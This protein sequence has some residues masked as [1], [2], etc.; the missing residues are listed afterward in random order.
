MDAALGPPEQMAELEEDLTPMMAQYYELC[1][2][3][4]DALV[5]FQVGDFYEAFCAAAKRVARL[6][7]I[8]LTQ[9]ED[10]TGEYPM[11]GIPIDNAESYVET[12]LDAGYRVA[13]ADQ[14]E[15]PDEVSGVVERAVTR[16]VTPGTLTESELLGGADNNYVA[17]L[18]AGERYGLALLDISTGDCYA[19]SVGSESAVA[20]ELSRFGPAEAIVGPDVDVD[21]D[22]VFGPACL[23]TRYDADAF[24]Q[25]RA[26]DRV[27]QYFGPPERLL[28][29]G[30][31]IR[32]CGGLLAYAEYTRGSSGAVGPDGEPV[33][34]DVDPAGTL[35]YL[36]HL[37]RYDPREY[38]LLDAVAVESLELFKRRSVRGHEN[39]TLVDTV[40]ETAC[41]LGRR[42]LTDW[43]RRPLLDADRIEARHGA[44][45]ELQRDPATRE[46]LSAL[47][48]EVYDLERLI[49][50]VSRGRAN[51]RDLRSLAATLSVVPDIRDHLADADARLLA[52]LHA[53]LD[54][55][56]ETREEIEAAIR[57][58]PPQQVTEGGVIREG[59]D[60]ELDRLR[61]TEQSGKEWIDELEASERERTGIDSLKVGHTSVHGYYIEVTNAN[62]DAVPEDYQ[63]RQTLK[64][65]ERYYTPAL[66][67]REDEI[68][69]AESAADDL[70]YD[71]FCAVRDE[72][73]DEA[74]RV[75][76]LAD[77]LARLDVLV[78]FAEVAAQYDYC[79][80][81]VGSD[82]IDVT[83]GRHPVVERTEDAFIPN[84]THLGSGP[85]P[86]SR[87]GSDD[88]VTADDIQ[89]FLAV[90]TGP[91]MSGKSTYM[92]QVALICLLAQSGSFVPAKAADLPILD[93]VF[94]RV[95]ASDDIAGGRSTFMI[96]MTELATILD[97]ATENSLVLL[98]EVGRGTST[99]DGLAI[100]RAVTEYLH[101][102]VGAYTLFATHHHDLTAVAAALSGATNRH[103]ETSR[104]D[105]DVRFDHEL[106]PGPAAASYGV[107]VASMAGVPDSVVERSRDLLA[108]A[109]TADTGVE[110]TRETEVA[111]E[112]R[113]GT[114]ADS[115]TDS[116][117]TETTGP[118]ENGAASAPAG[119]ATSDDHAQEVFQT[120]GAA[121]EDELPESVAQQLASLDVATMTPIEAMNALADLQ[122]RI[123]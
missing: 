95:G 111:S 75:Q 115:E 117:A 88:G 18:T 20:D 92:R 37:T 69:R 60:E 19:T 116:T 4:D 57:P 2:Q 1:R 39:R 14:V 28:A 79:R 21:R 99:A 33:D 82:G 91:N 58:D 55:L 103:F 114:R 80:P 67:E 106:A 16:I 29:G 97:A 108:D 101:D 78:S 61:S 9:R 30:A 65:S 71:L 50:R 41:A 13:I 107:E 11:A 56:A 94:T 86:A 87:D 27:G 34:P 25:D 38:M 104:E 7:E 15:D 22:A 36:N 100:A 90:V 68:L 59:Y 105:G 46:E 98:D 62:L 74:E 93:R 42:K 6:C 45:A 96:E 10:S 47:L 32:A 35:D 84:D 83:A 102:E 8:T 81:T 54:P 123:E 5:L 53:T 110:A 64:N 23:V 119:E 109:E 118:T 120:N 112:P 66:K 113:P 63:R 121:A 72:V 73:A 89:P 51:A 31:E 49:S 52:D 85:V 44:V 43:L 122:D 12:L 70:E 3:Y 24:A 17:A 77:R 48:A 76:A 40:D 26:E